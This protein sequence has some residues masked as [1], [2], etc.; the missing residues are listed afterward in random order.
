MELL[1]IANITLGYQEFFELARQQ[2]PFMGWLLAGLWVFNI[3]NWVVFR[4]RLDVFGIYPRSVRGLFGIIFAP[5][6]HGDF[7]HLFFNSIP[8]F[9]LGMFI[10]ALGRD[11]FIAVS[12]LIALLSGF[13]VWLFGRKYLHIGAS[14]VI[15]GYFVLFWINFCRHHPHF[16]C[17]IMGMPFD[18]VTLWCCCDVLLLVYSRI[19]NNCISNA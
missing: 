1:V 10:L 7:N 9:A 12:I 3:I 17:S 19:R 16:C 2:L 18:R 13:L 8:L 4:S 5:F 11:V 14:G 6:L 15:T